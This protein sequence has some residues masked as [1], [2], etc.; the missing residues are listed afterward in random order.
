MGRRPSG[1]QP[2][3]SMVLLCPIPLTELQKLNVKHRLAGLR[4]SDQ[5]VE[6]DEAFM[7]GWIVYR[8]ERN[9]KWSDI[10]WKH[11]MNQHQEMLAESYF[12]TYGPKPSNKRD[13]KT[14]N[15]AWSNM[16]Y[17]YDQWK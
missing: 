1:T 12:R 16:G 9:H 14:A 10:E 3:V 8:M 15:D 4:C 17:D 2:M 11:A 13:L 6:C 5:N 7:G